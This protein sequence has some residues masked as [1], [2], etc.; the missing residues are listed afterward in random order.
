MNKEDIEE[1]NMSYAPDKPFRSLHIKCDEEPEVNSKE[2]ASRTKTYS[3][4]YSHT[5]DL[6][7]D[8]LQIHPLSLPS[9]SLPKGSIYS[10]GLTIECDNV[11]H[12]YDSSKCHNILS[13]NNL[14]SSLTIT[15]NA[16]I[17]LLVEKDDLFNSFVRLHK[18]D[19]EKNFDDVII[20][21]TSGYATF[22]IINLMYA[23]FYAASQSNL[24]LPAFFVVTD[25]NHAGFDIYKNIK[26]GSVQTP[27][28]NICTSVPN[29]YHAGL[30]F[31][32][33]NGPLKYHVFDEVANKSCNTFD[34]DETDLKY[35][36]EWTAHEIKC[37]KSGF[38]VNVLCHDDNYDLIKQRVIKKMAELN[39]SSS[40][41]MIPSPT[42][43][44]SCSN[45]ISLPSTSTAIDKLTAKREMIS[46]LEKNKILNSS[47]ED[48]A[49]EIFDFFQK[50]YK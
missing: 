1:L 13:L 40:K 41:A 25:A 30:H 50:H 20:I 39:N 37:K 2:V 6:I 24:E 21:H 11:I 43:V 8:M 3:N 26:Y 48:T 15:T 9:L 44:A 35:L 33:Y 12:E 16:R 36:K 31:D 18:K 46:I 19:D 23:L 49:A 5:F 28:R 45:S 47:S 14:R 7:M 22:H 27:F 17:V 4:L 32:D 38:E 34:F 10:N 29:V 42:N